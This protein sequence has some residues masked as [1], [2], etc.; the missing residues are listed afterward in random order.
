MVCDKLHLQLDGKLKKI[1][2]EYLISSSNTVNQQSF[3]YLHR[4]TLSKIHERIGQV[5]SYFPSKNLK[6]VINPLS[7]LQ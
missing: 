1:N 5:H 7:R 2:V 4:N 6:S 3:V